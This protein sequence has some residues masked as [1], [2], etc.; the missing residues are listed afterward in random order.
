MEKSKII[1]QQDLLIE[2]IIGCVE[3]IKLESEKELSME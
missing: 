1:N 2:Q 3:K